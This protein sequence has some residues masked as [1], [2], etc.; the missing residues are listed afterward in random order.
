MCMHCLFVQSVYCHVS[1][2]LPVIAFYD[3]QNFFAKVLN[4]KEHSSATCIRKSYS[5]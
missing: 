5:S 2:R 3:P 1:F 4:L